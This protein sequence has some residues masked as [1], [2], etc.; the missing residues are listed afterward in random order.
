M[1][2]I[3]DL[4]EAI[5]KVSK[6][7]GHVAKGNLV[8]VVQAN[9]TLT[10][11]EISIQLH[12]LNDRHAYTEK[13]IMDQLATLE[14][15]NV[16]S[17]PAPALAAPAVPAAAPPPPK[18]TLIASSRRAPA[19]W[20][21]LREESRNRS[22]LSGGM[23]SSVSLTINKKESDLAHVPVIADSLPLLVHTETDM[24]IRSARP[25]TTESADLDFDRDFEFAACDDDEEKVEFNPSPNRGSRPHQA[26]DSFA[27]SP[28]KPVYALAQE[29]APTTS[30]DAHLNL[31]Q[32]SQMRGHMVRF[33]DWIFLH[34]LLWFRFVLDTLTEV[35]L[36][37]P[38]K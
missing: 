12:Q 4:Y 37:W 31:K 6:K 15:E 2:S 26:Y 23:A 3:K 7:W 36:E 13:A 20:Q 17:A 8:K 14:Q 9:P 33:G 38:P 1:A 32:I 30:S 27:T 28:K 24:S 22:L 5:P 19:S 11:M 16:A 29:D 35:K 18:L 10:P 34:N 25:S 21:S